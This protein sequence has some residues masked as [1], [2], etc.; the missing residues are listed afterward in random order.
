MMNEVGDIFEKVIG[1]K[2]GYI[3]DENGKFHKFGDNN[4]KY[5]N[6]LGVKYSWFKE[7]V[8]DNDERREEFINYIHKLTDQDS[9]YE[10]NELD[11][12][13]LW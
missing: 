2:Q 7:S 8:C 13:D 1:E 9:I 4:E 5:I 3:R 12:I 6:L 10:Y 11:L